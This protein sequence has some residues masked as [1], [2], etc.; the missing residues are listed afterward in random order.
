[1]RRGYRESLSKIG[2]SGTIRDNVSACPKAEV[3]DRWGLLVGG[4]GSK[5][6]KGLLMEGGCLYIGMLVD[7]GTAHR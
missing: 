4:V 6:F 3:A 2:K 1:M 7:G 5:I